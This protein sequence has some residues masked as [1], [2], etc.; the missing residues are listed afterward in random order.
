LYCIVTLDM[1]VTLHCVVLLWYIEDD[2]HS[3]L[4][5]IEVWPHF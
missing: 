3:V 1:I 5:C 4:Y 2:C